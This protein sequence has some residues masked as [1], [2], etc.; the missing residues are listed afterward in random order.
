MSV[1]ASPDG[2]RIYV[3]GDFTTANGQPRRRVAAYSTAT[4]ALITSFNPVGVTSQARAVI[5]TNDTV[6]VGGG[7]QGAGG[8]GRRNLAAFRA[9]DGGAAALEPRRRLHRVGARDL[10]RRHRGLRRRFVPERRRPAGLRHGQ[11]QRRD[12]CAHA[13]ERDQ[14]RAQRRR[15]LG[16]RQPAGP[17]QQRLRHGLA[18]RT[19]RQHR[20]HVQGV[21]RAPATSNGSPTAT[22]TCTPASCSP[23]SCTRSAT[24]TTAPTWAAASPSTRSGGS[25]TPRRGRTPPA[26][27]SSTTS[28]ATRTGTASQRAHRSSTG[29]PTWPSDRSPAS[30]RPAGT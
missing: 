23:A 12:R 4:G 21:G 5:A 2:S 22:A 28:T 7:F 15:G 11:D 9:S 6:Y 26:G 16:D 1:A 8:T 25:S 19:G 14:H 17:G 10:H 30:T 29:C 3:V 13:V 18:L 20:R 24:P 27:R